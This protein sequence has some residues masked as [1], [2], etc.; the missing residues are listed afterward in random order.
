MTDTISP[1]NKKPHRNGTLRAACVLLLFVPQAAEE[2]PCIRLAHKLP[3]GGFFFS[4]P[5]RSERIAHIASYGLSQH[6]HHHPLSLPSAASFAAP[7]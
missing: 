1:I 4:K 5:G 7:T 6:I 2:C 3:L